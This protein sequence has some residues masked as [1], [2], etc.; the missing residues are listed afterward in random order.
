MAVHVGLGSIIFP[1]PIKKNSTGKHKCNF[2]CF[3]TPGCTCAAPNVVCVGSNRRDGK[4]VIFNKVDLTK[5]ESMEI[6]ND[7]L[8]EAKE[9][10]NEPEKDNAVTTGL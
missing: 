7:I 5:G 1:V 8:E 6:L 2:C 3:N 4:E 9:G 10:R